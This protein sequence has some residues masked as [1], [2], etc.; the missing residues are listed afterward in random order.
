MEPLCRDISGVLER[1]FSAGVERLLVPS[2][3]SSN[4]DTCAD[5]S[6]LP[7]IS[8]ALGIHPWW[9]A[10]GIEVEELRERLIKTGAVAIGEIGLDWKTEVPRQTQYA[11]FKKQLELAS[12]LNIPV[13]LHCRG[14]FEEMLQLLK[15]NPVRG[16]IHG[17]SR[18]FQL[19]NRFIEAGLSISF[20]GAVT[21]HDAKKCRE[22]AARVPFDRFVL[23]TD[24]P[25]MG[26]KG[27]SPGE[28]EPGHV[29]DVLWA[30]AEIRGEATEDT[31]GAAWANSVALFG[32]NA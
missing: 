15:D 28:C 22:S 9:A 17:W 1:A 10:E 12:Q 3:S 30:F 26:L 18:D 19:M 32:G 27:V 13:I 23:E 25:S 14:A 24:S 5:L 29:A 20:G 8:C 31:A 11:V 6:L 2:V 21:R 16:V 7:G 4:W